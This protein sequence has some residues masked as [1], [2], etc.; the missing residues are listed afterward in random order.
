M[1][2]SATSPSRGLVAVFTPPKSAQNQ[3]IV[4][5]CYDAKIS[6]GNLKFTLSANLKDINA[7]PQINALQFTSEDYL[8]AT[9]SDK[10]I[11]FDLKRGV[12]S[13][14]IDISQGDLCGVVCREER[15]YA[16]VRKDGK[17]IIFIYDTKQN[18][19]IVKKVK[20]GSCDNDERLG[21]TLH[22]K[23][24]TAAIC[25]GKKLKLIQLSNGEVLTKFKIKAK[26][27]GKVSHGEKPCIVK[28][29]PD[30]KVIAASTSISAHFFS[31][32]SG[33]SIGILPLNAF[34][35]INL[36]S[37]QN[38]YVATVVEGGSKASIVE[39]VLNAKKN[40]TL[41]PFATTTM[42]AS[43]ENKTLCEA[44]FSSG[45]LG[46]SE[47]LLLELT[48]RGINNVDVGMTR[49]SYRSE[50]NQLESGELYPKQSEE[51]DASASATPSKSKKRKDNENVVL[52]PGESGGEALAVTEQSKRQKL[53]NSGDKNDGDDFVLEDDE[54]EET[55]AQRLA[56][57]SSELDRDTEDE[58]ELL[59]IQSDV[60]KKFIVKQAT[61]DSL[62]IVLRQAL[63]S[64]DDAQLEV[65]LQ[66][67]DKKVIENSVI[68][69]SS[70]ETFSGD[71]DED[72][73]EESSEIVIML[74]TKLVTRLARK[75]A[76]AQRLSF[77]IRTVLVTLISK[78]ASSDASMGKAERDVAAR[79]GPL[80]NLLNERVESLPELLRLEGRLALINTQL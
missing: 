16:L 31:V 4:I 48:P 18:N 5:K 20:C 77:W 1:Y 41:K 74:L 61:A 57:L 28:F 33:N 32:E 22:P 60:S 9:L 6:L 21:I 46:S 30:G 71:D 37:S 43:V 58:E 36:H 56:L 19:K 79:L 38:T 65:A 17:A 73:D 68:A 47:I 35:S 40:S 12:H 10:I 66:V 75:P 44:F 26:D 62:V 50:A 2:L 3:R 69:L 13:D 24:D 29:S 53:D 76:R 51:D 42:P 59:Q 23:D 54:G 8:L 67:S 45:K 80:R 11:I 39:A 25:V 49:V 14:T 15:V 27:D 70:N 7:I 64:N 78:L 63:Q 52:G 72:N 34:S 55:I